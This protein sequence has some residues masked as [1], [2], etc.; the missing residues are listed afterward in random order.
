MR[1][2]TLELD[3]TTQTAKIWDSGNK[4]FHASNLPFV[5]QG[6]RAVLRRPEHTANKY[7][8][9]ASFKSPTQNEVLASV[10]K[11]TGSKWNHLHVSSVEQTRLGLEALQS[12]EFGDAFKPLLLSYYYGDGIDSGFRNEEIA[13]ELLGLHYE[14]LDDTLAVWLKE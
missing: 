5:G 7:L 9:I 10:E 13:N 12:K 11:L 6:V 4:P 3:K 14:S 8:S 1:W 2:G